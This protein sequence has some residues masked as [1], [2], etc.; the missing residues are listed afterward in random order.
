MKTSE[1]KL[2]KKM[3][4]W[5]INESKSHIR[6]INMFNKHKKYDDFYEFIELELNPLHLDPWSILRNKVAPNLSEQQIQEIWFSGRV[7]FP[8][9]RKLA[10]KIMKLKQQVS[11]LARDLEEQILIEKM[12]ISLNAKPDCIYR[13]RD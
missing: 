3:M 11:D 7:S 9:H 12:S 10:S 13:E 4:E 6:R 2:F 1:T 5:H 8:T